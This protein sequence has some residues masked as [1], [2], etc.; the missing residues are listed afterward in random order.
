MYRLLKPIEQATAWLFRVAR[1]KLTDRHR[2]MKPDL[3]EDAFSMEGDWDDDDLLLADILKDW[4]A[5]P[6]DALWQSEVM[7]AITEA[8]DELPEE[9]SLVFVQ[10]ELEGRSFKELSEETGLPVNTLIS[11][12]RYAVLYLREHLAAWYADLEG[13]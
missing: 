3:L 4:S 8:L 6:E 7:E 11:R 1:N 2:K 12:K 13:A 10:H 9:Q 5:T